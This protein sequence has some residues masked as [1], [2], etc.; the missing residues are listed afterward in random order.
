VPSAQPTEH[1]CDKCGSP[2][3]L[4]EGRRGP[5][6]G[7]TAY[8]K[9]K[10]ILDVDAQG[11]PIRPIT[12]DVACEKCGRP[13]I[14]KPTGARGPFLACSGYPACRSYKPLPADLKERL[15]DRLPAPPPKKTMPA[16]EV[17]ETCPDCGGPMKLRPGRKG[18]FLG[19]AKYPKCKGTR[20]ASPELLEKLEEAGA[21]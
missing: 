10:N 20:E 8:P 17:S 1:V 19:C 7:C 15:K 9:C 11:N 12:T 2:M 14:V 16:V 4:R 3:A 5:F 21:T 6:L 18:P 13:M